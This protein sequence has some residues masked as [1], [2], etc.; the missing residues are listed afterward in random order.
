[1]NKP[2]KTDAA[3]AGCQKPE[4]NRVLSSAG[5]HVLHTDGAVGSIPTAPTTN[6][7]QRQVLVWA[8]ATFGPVA[9]DRRERAMRFVEEAIE[10]AQS[11]GLDR[12]T[13][14]AIAERAYSRRAGTLDREL[15]QAGMT[16]EALAENIGFDLSRLIG[17]E[18]NRVREVPKEEWARRHAA[19]T[20]IGITAD[21][22]SQLTEG[23]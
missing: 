9:A 12:R 6:P 5:E 14:D 19:K 22:P 3:G 20:A 8:I 10:L 15:A 16:L 11:C 7:R 4:V 18:F 17:D 1:M 13:I 23:E 2:E 21:A